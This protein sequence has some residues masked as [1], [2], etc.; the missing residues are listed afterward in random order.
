[1][2]KIKIIFTLFACIASVYLYGQAAETKPLRVQQDINKL[3]LQNEIFYPVSVFSNPQSKIEEGIGPYTQLAVDKQKIKDVFKANYK[4]IRLD[5][6]LPGNKSVNVLLTQHKIHS[7]DFELTITDETGRHRAVMND[8]HYYYG[9]IENGSHTMAAISIFENEISGIITDETGNWNLGQ[10]KTRTSDYVFFNDHTFQLPIAFSCSTED[11]AETEKKNG[12]GGNN[13]FATEVKGNCVKIFFDCGFPFYQQ[14]GSNS[15]NVTNYTNSIFNVMQTIYGNDSIEISIASIHIWTTTDPFNYTSTTTGVNSFASWWVANGGYSGNIAALLTTASIGGGKAQN[16]GFVCAQ[17]G[18]YS[19]SGINGSGLNSYPT[20]SW[21]AFVVSHECGHTLGSRH[22]HAC[23]W[24][25]NNTALDGCAG[26]TEGGC[27]LPGN[28]AGGGTIMSYCHL[29]SGVGIN[30]SNGFGAQPANKIRTSIAAASC[31]NVCTSCNTNLSLSG[32]HFSY[33]NQ[34]W[35]ATNEIIGV[36]VLQQS[37]SYLNFNA[38]VQVKLQPN[39]EV[40]HGATFH[41]AVGC[42]PSSSP[43]MA[44]FANAAKHLALKQT[45]TGNDLLVSPNPFAEQIKA[46]FE[47]TDMAQVTVF[48]IDQTGRTALAVLSNQQMETGRQELLLNTSELS[49]GM[50][51]LVVSI[52]DVKYSTKI[53]KL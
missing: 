4:S 12:G 28:P 23:V 22:T 34:S 52:N 20:Y 49:P 3:Q 2:K 37:G 41:A 35:W 51:F 39:F 9:V 36:N 53:I 44:P 42:A 48:I 29:V 31:I 25:G 18:S 43:P 19:I 40:Q 24:N 27:A 45:T 10:H 15:T 26:S 13:T 30:F 11:E 7:D 47:L 17:N 5:I 6:P 16:F 50:Y 14:Q 21:D 33:E 32:T 38:G 8:G 46:A 1:M